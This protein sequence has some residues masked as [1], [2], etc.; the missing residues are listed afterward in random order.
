MVAFK[1]YIVRCIWSVLFIK[2]YLVLLYYIVY[3]FIWVLLLQVF[4]LKVNGVA[5]RFIPDSSQVAKAI[6]VSSLSL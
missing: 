5:F 6:K 2:I 3:L 4:E 1:R